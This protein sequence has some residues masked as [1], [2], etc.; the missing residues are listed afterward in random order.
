VVRGPALVILAAGRARRYGAIKPLAPIGPK[1]EAVID[2]IAS[3]AHDAGF[4]SIVL[5]L[6][7]ETGPTIWEHVTTHW[8]SHVPVA[9]VL[10]LE[11]RGT[12]D[13]VLAA[14]SVLDGQTFAVCNADD[15]YGA[16]AMAALGH[17]LTTVGTNCLVGFRLDHAL[18]GEL[19][20]TR[21]VCECADD[22]SP[23]ILLDIVER[24]HVQR[25]ADGFVSEDGREP[26]MLADDHLV[27]MNLWGFQPA[28]WAV[29]QRAMDEAVDASADNEVLLPEIVATQLAVPGMSF[30]VLETTSSC[31]GV[32]HPDDLAL[33][34][35][36][37]AAQIARGE[38]S[39]TLFSRDPR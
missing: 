12:V 1:D 5:V 7:P 17:H 21:G 26:R 11:P 14:K 29:L 33:V 25:T 2:L 6:N 34:K 3:D 28:M 23:Y 18:V 39:G 10:Q 4:A 19:P 13:A 37:V 8:P 16:S 22:T 15:L 9:S 24:R 38:R 31:V 32:T 27:S 30:A 35:A 20:V 36:E